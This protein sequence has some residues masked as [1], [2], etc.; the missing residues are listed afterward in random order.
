MHLDHLNALFLYLY[1]FLIKMLCF[2]SFKSLTYKYI[3]SISCCSFI[4]LSNVFVFLDPE[5]P[6]I[7]IQYRWSGIYG[8]FSL[9]SLLFLL[10]VL[11]KLI[12]F[13]SL[14][15]YANVSIPFLRIYLSSSKHDKDILLVL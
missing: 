2:G 10:V 6:I 9:Y 1:V 14:C 3:L 4:K 12:I 8:H 11:S 7:K 5:P 13:M 15:Q